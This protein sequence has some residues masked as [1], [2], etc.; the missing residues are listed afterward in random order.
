[1]AYWTGTSA[2]S[3]SNNLFW[4]NTNSRLGIG[5]NAPETALNIIYNN[6]TY[7]NGIVIRNTNTGTTSMTG[8]IL[9]DSANQFV[10]Q[11]SYI[12]SNYITASLR[13]TIIFTSSGLQKLGFIAN[14]GGISNTPQ[15]IYF[16]TYSDKFNMYLYGATGNLILQN[17]G[18]FTDNGQR[19]QVQGTTLLNGNVTF[20]S[21][22][23]MFWDATNSRLGIGTNAPAYP[24][25]I[26]TSSR[27]GFAY[28]CTDDT[29]NQ[30]Y[31]FL[32]RNSATPAANDGIGTILLEGNNSSLVRSTYA[33]FGGR[34]ITST[35]GSHSG[36]LYFAT[37]NGGTEADK[38]VIK[39]TGNVLIQNG[40]TFTD[41]G[42]R[43]Q[44]TGTMKV[45]GA[46]SFGGNMSL[47]L[48]Q[49]ATTSIGITNTTN[50]ISSD[51]QISLTSNSTSGT[52]SFT[53]ASTL[54]TAY[55]TFLGNDALIY[56]ST[57]GDISVLNDWASG[58]IKFAA[59]GS[60]TSHLT[61]KSNGRITMSSLPTSSSGLATGDLWNDA[62]TLKI[63]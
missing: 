41:S 22:T 23:G 15:D 50:G 54:K 45:T 20:S 33:Y 17:G 60:S 63:V 26:R 29:A 40:G 24:L 25:H 56:N 14:A 27:F 9:K 38:L 13:N 57:A 59:G 31:L 35:A 42:E 11:F 18:T 55:K 8:L 19:L 30:N 32:Y 10:G 5:T 6:N 58:N 16:Q 43:L 47:A 44:V 53:K 7:S 49:N 1:V 28:E 52:A 61:I 46:S 2:Q 4:D 39:P 37:T 21:A 48:N 51:L 12:P 34:I 62:G 3:G 36:E